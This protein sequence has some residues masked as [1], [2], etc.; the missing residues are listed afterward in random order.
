[1]LWILIGLNWFFNVIKLVTKVF[2]EDTLSS[3]L[4]RYF[5]VFV[6]DCN[7]GFLH[8]ITGRAADARVGDEI[9]SQIV[10]PSFRLHSGCFVN[11]D[12]K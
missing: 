8:L 11:D 9:V 3:K 7:Q 5:E 10:L 4:R 12:H 6:T 1:M 2:T